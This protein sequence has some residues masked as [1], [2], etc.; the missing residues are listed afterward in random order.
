MACIGELNS[1]IR[2]RTPTNQRRVMGRK[3]AL[4]ENPACSL[5]H[6]TERKLDWHQGSK[7]GVEMRGEHGSRDTFPRHIAHHKVQAGVV[8]GI[9]D[10]AVI[11]AHYASGLVMIANLPAIAIQILVRQQAPLD[12]SSQFQVVL[13]GIEFLPVHVV[14][15]E[16]DQRVGDQTLAFDGIVA[17]LADAER[18]VLHPLERVIDLFEQ[19]SQMAIAVRSFFSASEPGAPV[20]QLLAHKTVHYASHSGTPIGTLMLMGPEKLSAAGV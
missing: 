1:A 16:P 3:C 17:G 14:E 6:A 19:G 13:K 4:R 11:A 15:A 18:A 9:D 10:V 2:K 8:S 20:E 5:E 7:H 12:L